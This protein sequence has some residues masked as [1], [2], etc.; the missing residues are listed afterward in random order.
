MIFERHRPKQLIFWRPRTPWRPKNVTL[1]TEF[2][3]QFFNAGG[4]VVGRL[5]GL[6]VEG[7][8]VDAHAE[9]TILLALE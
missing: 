4:H 9:F 3:K 8:V 2:L 5:D 1:V 6:V 7:S